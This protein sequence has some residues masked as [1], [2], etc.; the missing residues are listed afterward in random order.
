MKALF[1]N[2]CLPVVI[3]NPS[4]NE[5]HNMNSN[6]FFNFKFYEGLC[7]I[8]IKISIFCHASLQILKD[9]SIL[10]AI[11]WQMMH[12]HHWCLRLL[13]RRNFSLEY[14]DPFGPGIANYV[15]WLPNNGGV[16]EM[17]TKSV[18]VKQNASILLGMLGHL[19]VQLTASLSHVIRDLI[20]QQ[21]VF[22]PYLATYPTRC[23]H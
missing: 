12:F 19:L 1:S 13:L 7:F 22:L 23:R 9:Y 20:N 16:W 18:Y 15:T 14:Y 2:E 17:L 4:R 21:H 11:K 10:G 3:Q 6:P 5:L 8:L